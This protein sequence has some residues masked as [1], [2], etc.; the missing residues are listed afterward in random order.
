V[1]QE[2]AGIQIRI[3]ELG[4]A[5]EKQMPGY[6]GM[7]QIIHRELGEHPELLYKLKDEEI[8]IVISGMEKFHEIE[9]VEVKDKKTITK[10]QGNLLDENSV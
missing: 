3:A 10:K 8:A 2:L 4:Q 9:I 7:L 5:I 6:K 1:T